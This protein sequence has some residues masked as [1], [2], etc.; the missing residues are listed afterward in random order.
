MLTIALVIVLQ[1]DENWTAQRFGSG[2]I[3]I[4][5]RSD[6]ACFPLDEDHLTAIRSPPLRLVVFVPGVQNRTDRLESL[7]R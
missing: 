5:I 4:L 7:I 3:A 6:C 2:G 1:E